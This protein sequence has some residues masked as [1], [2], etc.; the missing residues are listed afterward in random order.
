MEEDLSTKYPNIKKRNVLSGRIIESSKWS[1]EN[2]SDG[3]QYFFH[4][5][6]RYPMQREI[7]DFEYLPN[8]RTLERNFGGLVSV[9]E[10]LGLPI[11]ANFTRGKTRSELAAKLQIQGAEAEERLYHIL[12]NILHP[13]RVHEQK[14][15]RPNNIRCDFYLYTSVDTGIIID[16]FVAKDIFSLKGIINIKEDKYYGVK[17]PVYFI[18]ICDEATTSAIAQYLKGKKKTVYYELFKLDDFIERIDELVV[19]KMRHIEL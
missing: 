4:L 3:L 1:L 8:V 11:P 14:T 17:D 12:I 9:R 15:I 19:K 6:G 18:A 7:N 10:R 13:L 5:H 16:I 2:V